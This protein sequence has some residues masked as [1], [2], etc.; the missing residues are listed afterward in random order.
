[1]F[2]IITIASSTTKPVAMV[3]AISVRL[4]IEKPAR[5][6]TPKVPT[7]DSGTATLGM[8]VAGDV[9]QEQEDHHHHQRDGEQQLELHV[10]HRGADGDG[11]VGE[12]RRR[13]PRPAAPPAAA[14]AACLTRS[15]TSITL[16]PGWRWMLRMTAGVVVRPRGEAHVLGVVDDVGDVRQAHRRAVAV[17][18]DELAV[19]V[20][21]AQL[22]VGVDGGGARRAVEA[23]LG[24][25][26]VGGGDRGAHVFE[27]RAVGGERL[28]VRP[29]R[30]PRAAGRR[31]C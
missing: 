2:S 29:A 8:S 30:A 12:Q 4:L 31:R 23:A 25:V 1:M 16:A 27:V 10:A 21:R 26:D 9:A 14:A 15:T 19:L 6:M 18:D 24:L 13:R 7:S 3:S 22:V 28:R 11:A 20:G 5:Y 17:G